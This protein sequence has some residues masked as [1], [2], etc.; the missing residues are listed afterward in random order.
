MFSK[1]YTY[2]A[3]MFSG[4]LVFE[5]K[6]TIKQA[7][8]FYLVFVPLGMLLILGL[9]AIFL[10][11]SA[12]YDDGLMIGARGAIVLT[13]LLSFLIVYKKKKLQDFRVVL[14]GVLAVFVSTQGV[15]WSGIFVAWL[16]CFKSHREVTQSQQN[17][18]TG[19][20]NDQK[21]NLL[22]IISSGETRN[23]EFK[24]TFSLETK[25]KNKEKY[26]IEGKI[27][28]I[29]GF[30]NTDGGTLIIGVDDEG[31][32]IGINEEIVLLHGSDDKYLRAVKDCMRDEIGRANLASYVNFTIE[33]ESNKKLLVITCQKSTEPV[34]SA[35]GSF[36]KVRIGSSNE[37]LKVRDC[38]QYVNEH[39]SPKEKDQKA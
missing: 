35:D 34:Y 25:T 26:L 28:T 9:G 13:F 7:I 22:N 12:T 20:L 36:F 10:K 15:I 4:L 14:V 37:S 16:T 8:G 18:D 31:R 2:I 1:I 17:T 11:K 27:K 24:E 38:V 23:T 19:I 3:D 33:T 30:L 29:A 39:F 21:L 32:T 5:K 6:R